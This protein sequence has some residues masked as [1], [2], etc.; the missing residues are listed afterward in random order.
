MKLFLTVLIFTITFNFLIASEKSKDSIY[1][2]QSYWM[3]EFFG[4]TLGPSI[5]YDYLLFSDSLNLIEF[6]LRT[7]LGINIISVQLPQTFSFTYG[8]KHKLE[9]AL[10]I[11][12]EYTGPKIDVDST[13]IKSTYYS[14]QIVKAIGFIGYKF[15]KENGTYW[16]FGYTPWYAFDG[17]Q[18][19]IHLFGI[20][21][22]W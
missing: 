7:G 22:G 10:G 3:I 6:R 15:I 9:V 4:N 8:R 19:S 2:N 17:I 14:E 20:S 12:L 13:T 11:N 16:R 5:N 18:K 21:Y 1:F